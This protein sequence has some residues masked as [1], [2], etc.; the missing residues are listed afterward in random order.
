MTH[1]GKKIPLD[2]SLDQMDKMLNRTLFFRINR[3]MIVNIDAITRINS[4]YNNRLILQLSP[5]IGTDDTI[6]SRERV[7]SFK[8]WLEGREAGLS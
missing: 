5:D 4:Y 2:Y 7:T 6:V 1:S 8:S 3:K